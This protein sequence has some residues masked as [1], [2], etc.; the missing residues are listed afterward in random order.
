W[1]IVSPAG[2]TTSMPTSSS[3]QNSPSSSGRRTAAG[4]KR[5]RPRRP[6]ASL[7]SL[8]SRKV[9]RG[10]R[11]VG[12]DVAT[13]RVE[14]SSRWTTAPV[15]N[16][17]SGRSVNTS[18]TTEPLSPCG[19]TTRPTTTRSLECS[20][21]KLDLGRHAFFVGGRSGDG[22]DRPGDAATSSDHPPHVSLG[23]AN[24][25]EDLVGPL[26]DDGDL[27]VVGIV[28]DLPDHGLHD[29]LD[30]L[31]LR[32]VSSPRTRVPRRTP[33]P[34]LPRRRPPQPLPPRTPLRHRFRRQAPR[35][36]RL[37]G[38]ISLPPAPRRCGSCL[39]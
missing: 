25:G 22:P 1:P 18:M 31:A 38:R 17:T 5:S 6:S 24:L 14:P 9:T 2:P 39:P 11:S 28:D 19:R 8:T 29:P 33:L 20:V 32:H 7:R 3:G 4:M 36:P 35:Q 13:V 27:D 34:R 10:R 12:W 16:R 30:D 26:F 37:P 21:D 15:A 23:S